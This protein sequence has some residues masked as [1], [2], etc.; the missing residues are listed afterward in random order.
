MASS[1]ALPIQR[2]SASGAKV[3]WSPIDQPEPVF[4]SWY[5][6]MPAWSLP[7]TSTA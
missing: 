5:Q 6:R 7:P 1:A 2:L 3:P 4:V